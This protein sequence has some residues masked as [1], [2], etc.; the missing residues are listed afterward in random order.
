MDWNDDLYD[1]N[2][3][4][5]HLGS[6]GVLQNHTVDELLVR[7]TKNTRTGNEFGFKPTELSVGTTAAGEYFS[8]FHALVHRD[9]PNIHHI[10]PEARHASSFWIRFAEEVCTYITRNKT[11]SPAGGISGSKSEHF[12]RTMRRIY[13]SV[14]I[15]AAS[16][17][18]TLRAAGSSFVH[19]TTGSVSPCTSVSTPGGLLN[20]P[21]TSRK[22]S[23]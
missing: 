9:G 20:M 2:E 17:F 18:A 5:A 23:P 4:G 16:L 7:T 10:D 8:G 11:F 22:C 1:R 15:S 12:A 19:L 13:R 3:L 21:A 6:L 14:L